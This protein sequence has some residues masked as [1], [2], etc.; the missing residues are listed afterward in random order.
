MHTAATRGWTFSSH[1]V[2]TIDAAWNF[3]HWASGWLMN[4][5]QQ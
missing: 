4:Q 3:D 2:P 5:E 1:M